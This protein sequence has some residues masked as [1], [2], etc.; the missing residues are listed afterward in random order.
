MY[1]LYSTLLPHM[2][3][4]SSP[5]T[6]EATTSPRTSYAESPSPR[7][8]M[9][10]CHTPRASYMN[11]HSPRESFTN[12]QSPRT[13]FLEAYMESSASFVVESQSPRKT[14]LATTGDSNRFV[15]INTQ[16][17]VI[18]TGIKYTEVRKALSEQPL[19]YQFSY[20]IEC[21]CE[22]GNFFGSR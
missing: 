12:A 7:T 2:D 1:M 21:F 17:L 20:Y 3:A 5:R 8:S 6:F 13:S 18:T 11:A 10:N 16:R 14:F 22:R 9:M 4:E 15:D 19:I